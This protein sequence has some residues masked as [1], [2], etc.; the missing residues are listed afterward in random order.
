MYGKSIRMSPVIAINDSVTAMISEIP[1][2]D[3][4]HRGQ[5]PDT[6]ECS[7]VGDLN[8]RTLGR[9]C[10]HPYPVPTFLPPM[11]IHFPPDA[12]SAQW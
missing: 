11:R 2:P 10:L 4:K 1:L 5:E 3:S 9:Q 8:I 6:V 7:G 12:P